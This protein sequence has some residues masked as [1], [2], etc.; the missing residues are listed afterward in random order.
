MALK[1]LVYKSIKWLDIRNPTPEEIKAIGNLYP[2]VH[3]LNIEDMLSPNERPKLDIEDDYIFIVLHFPLWDAK[4]RLTRSRE[5]NILVMKSAI[6]TIHDGSLKP[7]TALYDRCNA[8]PATLDKLLGKSTETTLY[9]IVDN[10]VDYILPILRKVDINLQGVEETIF[11]RNSRNIIRDIAMIRRDIIALRRIIRQQVPVINQIADLDHPLLP[12]DSDQYFGD[13]VDHI[14]KARDMI[15]EDAEI[16]VSFA[17]TVNTLANH[18]VN[19]VIRVLTVISV[20]MLPLTLISS[21]Y[22][23]NIGLPFENHP[24]AFIIVSAFMFATAV[25]MLAFF[26]YRRW[27]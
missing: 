4:E 6:I 19:E 12:E 24:S 23:M 8:D 21:I 10:L 22:G 15:D 25:F 13:I 2:F 20:I 27:I 9:T 3:P 11:H 26:R 7:L 1:T 16:I 5:V 18:R 17:D 14:E